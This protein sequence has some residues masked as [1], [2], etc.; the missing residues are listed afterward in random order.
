MSDEKEP[1]APA[2]DTDAGGET[3]ATP[4][5]PEEPIVP[6]SFSSIINPYPMM[7]PITLAV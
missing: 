4:A 5:S 2:N 6:S 1:S 3:D 7:R